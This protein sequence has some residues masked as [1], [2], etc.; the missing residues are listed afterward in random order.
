MGRM[1]CDYIKRLMTLTSDNIMRLSLHFLFI[2]VLLHR[3]PN[4]AQQESRQFF[5]DLKNALNQKRLGI[6]GLGQG[7]TTHVG[8]KNELQGR[9]P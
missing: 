8:L 3:V 4:I 9:A 2:D 7:W 1:N 5:W 6:T